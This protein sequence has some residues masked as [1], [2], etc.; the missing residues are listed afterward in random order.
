MLQAYRCL[1]GAL[2]AKSQEFDYLVKIGR[3]HTQDATPLTLGQEFSGY[4]TQAIFHFVTLAASCSAFR[5]SFCNSNA[6]ITPLAFF[7]DLREIFLSCNGHVTRPKNGIF[8]TKAAFLEEIW[9][10]G[11]NKPLLQ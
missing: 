4:T 3:T 1:Q 6:S 5:I 11:D 9:R 7:L 10:P 2:K 8:N